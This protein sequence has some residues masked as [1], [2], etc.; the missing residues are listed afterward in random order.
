VDPDDLVH[1]IDQVRFAASHEE[2]RPALTGVLFRAEDS[3]LVIA[4]TDGNRLAERRIRIE[5]PEG[6]ANALVPAKPLAMLG[7]LIRRGSKTSTLSI[8]GPDRDIR[9]ATA[10][11]GLSVRLMQNAYPNYSRL[12]SQS[13]TTRARVLIA[14]LLA[15]L[16]S[17]TAFAQDE[18]RR[19]EIQ[20]N[21]NEVSV[22]ATD[23]HTGH[24]QG[25]IQATVIGDPATSMV[26]VHYLID[27]LRALD[28]L[29]VTLQFSG[30]NKPLTIRPAAGGG[31]VN[32]IMPIHT[33]GS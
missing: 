29:E 6:V 22:R 8:V 12:I 26:N 4:A 1:A 23:A 7:G 2:S 5:N 17:I 15:D 9:F 21:A 18:A 33:G 19:V 14:P 25:S 27:A 11:G 20:A 3:E 32:V 10:Q 31:H 24:G 16:Q 13:G 28:D 30:P